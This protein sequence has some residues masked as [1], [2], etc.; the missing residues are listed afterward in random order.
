MLKVVKEQINL[1][2]TIARGHLVDFPTIP[3]YG[4]KLLAK[5]LRP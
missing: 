4:K 2:A 1:V 5:G 3:R